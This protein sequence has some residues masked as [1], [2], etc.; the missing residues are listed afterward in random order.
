MAASMLLATGSCLVRFGY[1]DVVS[2]HFVGD[3]H[4]RIVHADTAIRLIYKSPTVAAGVGLYHK[5][6]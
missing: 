2:S 4:Q 6:E 5:P 1:D 3:P